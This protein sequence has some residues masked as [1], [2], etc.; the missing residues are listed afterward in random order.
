MWYYADETIVKEAHDL[1]N[2]QEP[3]A[4]QPVILAVDDE[5]DD[6]ER[7]EREL[8]KRYEA[9]Y[10][11]VCEGSA[12]ARLRKLRDLKAAGEDVALVIAD[13]RMPGMSGVEFLACVRDIYPVAKRLLLIVP[14][15]RG[16]GAILPQA[17]SLAWIN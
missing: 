2:G 6:L 13:Q 16:T 1:V 14:M 10:R 7:V 9:D 3:K 11:M 15:D 17:M 12:E 4:F 5:Q 8:R